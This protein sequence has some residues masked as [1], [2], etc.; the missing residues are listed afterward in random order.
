MATVHI[1]GAGISGLAAASL[2]AEAHIPVKLY[3]ASTHA[4]GRARSSADSALGEVDHGLHLFAGSA[5]EFRRFLARID[6]QEHFSPLP[7][8]LMLHDLASGHSSALHMRAPRMAASLAE[9]AQLLGQSLHPRGT[10]ATMLDAESPLQDTLLTPLSRL[11]LQQPS[12]QASARHWQRLVRQW[13]RRGAGTLYAPNRPLHQALMAPALQRIEYL[14]G[15]VYFG[16]ALKSL[17][18]KVHGVAQLHFTRKKLP[19]SEADVV[20]LATPAPVTKG[21]LPALQIPS[22][23]HNAITYHFQCDAHGEPAGSYRLLSNGTADLIRYSTHHISAS[24]RTGDAIWARDEEAVA[25]QIWQQLQTLHPRLK[26][27][28]LP[29]YAIWREKRAGHVPQDAPLPPPALPP[30]LLLAGDWLDATRPATLE[31]AAHHGHRAAEEALLLLGKTPMPSQ[32]DFY[33][34]SRHRGLSSERN[35]GSA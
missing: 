8:P 12:H 4:G 3:E 14:G 31:A 27:L 20:I 19:L 5:R 33:L 34:K 29:A 13:L 22:Q 6:A 11:V 18:L 9:Y 23:Q 26:T 17:E 32:Y 7:A 2:L 10:V 30:R 16:Q 24:I 25:R 28:P 21:L 1:I 35:R 15:S